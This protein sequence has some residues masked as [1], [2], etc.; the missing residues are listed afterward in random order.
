MIK[1]FLVLLFLALAFVA[2]RSENDGGTTVNTPPPVSREV[3]GAAPGED[4]NVSVEEGDERLTRHGLDANLRF[5][6]PTQISVGMWDRASE[7]LPDFSQSHWAEWIIENALADHNLAVNF[8]T[9]PRW[10]EQ[11][12]LTTLL[13]A[14][15]APD[16]GYT[17]SFPMVE[18][19]AGMGAITDL[20]PI[21][22]EYADWAPNMFG[23]LTRDNVFWN[24]NPR[25]GQLWAIEGRLI[26]DGRVNTFIREDWLNT[27]GI[28][29]PNSLESF[30]AA[31]IAFRDNAEL[32]LGDDAQFMIPMFMGEDAAWNAQTL[33]ESFIPDSITEREWYVHGFDDRR[34]MHPT[35]KEA[36]RVVN[37]WFNDG[38]IYREFIHA[39]AGNTVHDDQIRLGYVGSM[40]ANWDL[41]FRAADR[42]TT[43]MRQHRGPD[44]NFIVVTPFPND[45]G[46]T[47]KYMPP[48]VDRKI[49]FPST[50]S[51]PV[52][53][54][55]YLDWI[56]RASV[57]EYLAFGIEGI[58]RQT[59]ENGAIMSLAEDDNHSF[60][61]NM[62]FGGLR[63]FDLTIT[64]NGIDLGDP[65]RTIA[66]LALNYPGIEPN[67][68]LDARNA[69]LNHMRVWRQVQT[70]PIDSQ[71]GMS[72]PLNDF[73]NTIL[74]NSIT[75][76]V[77]NFDSVWDSMFS[78]YLAVGGQDIINER[79]QAW[80]EEFGDVEFMPNWTGW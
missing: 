14:G 13:G 65:E 46:Q 57:R 56:S 37:R 26:A 53:S 66:T 44:A 58:H 47:V 69:G 77:D 7:R 75:A 76:S 60:P 63:N 71:E 39:N 48:P 34:F 22:T 18:T 33:I 28:A 38:L 51:N 11:A 29:P 21:V 42:F 23:L 9:I 79:R 74:H 70:R 8:I 45:S 27:L 80:I 12:F 20:A 49:F 55:L 41:P 16:I 17:F 50:N 15:N 67:A 68:V 4:A 5:L 32:L 59:L 2:C 36:F 78:Q 40:I 6:E 30:E 10:D 31:L 25:T 19:F 24:L 3:E 52:A 1:K 54:L 61:N 43:E 73:R 72:T 64:V 35:T 62:I